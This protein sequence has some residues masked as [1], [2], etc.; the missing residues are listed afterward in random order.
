[1]RSCMTRRPWTLTLAA[2]TLSFA[3]AGCSPQPGFEE[4]VRWS[5][6]PRLMDGGYEAQLPSAV[7]AIDEFAI[8]LHDGGE[9]EGSGLPRGRLAE[10]PDGTICTAVTD[11]APY[12]GPISWKAH[13][14]WGLEITY[15]GGSVLAN[16]VQDVAANDWGE[17]RIF[18]CN[19]DHGYW[20]VGI[21]C[22]DLG[23]AA[24]EA[25]GVKPC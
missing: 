21:E 20:R 4:P 14:D 8:E 19:I 11:E 3:L 5:V 17:L 24:N 23:A 16:S 22:G 10:R 6:A 12:S 25:Y 7:A 15:E 9:G 2:G 18:P 13:D 1:M